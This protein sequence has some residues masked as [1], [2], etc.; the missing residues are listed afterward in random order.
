M[1][2]PFQKNMPLGIDMRIR[3]RLLRAWGQSHTKVM[4]MATM[5]PA[6]AALL[7][8]VA[9]PEEQ[10]GFDAAIFI[11]EVYAAQEAEQ[12]RAETGIYH[13]VREIHEGGQKPSY[14]AAKEGYSVTA[15]ARTDRVETFQHSETALTLVESNARE[16]AVEVFLS[17]EHEEGT[18]ALHHFSSS[19]KDALDPA[20]LQYDNAHDLASL[21]SEYTSLASP[22]LPLLSSEALFVAIE[23]SSGT[24]IFATDLG[25]TLRLESVVDIETKLVVEERI[26]I[27]EREV[28]YE[29]TRVVYLEREVMPASE[30]EKIFDATAYEYE[31]VDTRV[32]L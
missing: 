9:P 15:Q 16:Q 21:Y 17:R 18:L 29:M 4:L 1:K 31:V 5:V 30:F 19:S 6:F 27:T 11:A 22:V 2:H 3:G 7:L 23:E 10:S 32:I 28:E 12:K 13:V 8:V 26:I 24:A 14:V 20:R 25:E